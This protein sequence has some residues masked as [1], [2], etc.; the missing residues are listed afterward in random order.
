VRGNDNVGTKMNSMELERENGNHHHHPKHRNVMKSHQLQANRK[1]TRSISPTH[2]VTF[3]HTFFFVAF[4]ESAHHSLILPRSRRRFDDRDRAR[5]VRPWCCGF[6]VMCG[7][8]RLGV[9]P[10]ENLHSSDET[11]SKSQTITVYRQMQWYNVPQ[12]SFINKV[13]RCV[14][15]PISP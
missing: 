11:V 12:L 13:D 14:V 6:G 8:W 10:C 3:I 7:V 1:S 15:L 2:L 4:I 9:F 5:V